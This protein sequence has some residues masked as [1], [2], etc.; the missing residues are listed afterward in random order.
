M[1]Y[2]NHNYKIRYLFFS[3]GEYGMYVS[4]RFDKYQDLK[5]YA[6]RKVINFFNIALIS[7][8]CYANANISREK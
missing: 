8:L 3:A 2:G 4:Q 7:R 6:A 1:R 5:M